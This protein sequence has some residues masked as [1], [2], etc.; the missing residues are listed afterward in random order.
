[1]QL[2]E[3]TYSESVKVDR[4]AGIIRDVKVL[5]RVSKNGREY[6][7]KALG[8]AARLYEGIKVRFD[9]P[10]KNDPGRERQF[11]DS[12]GRLENLRLTADGVFADLPYKKTH[13]Y[14][15]IVCESAERFAKDFGLSHNSEGAVVTKDGKVIVESINKARGVDV[16]DNPASTQG[17]FES[18]DAVP[19]DC[20]IKFNGDDK[21]PTIQLNETMDSN[22]SAPAAAADPPA[23]AAHDKQLKAALKKIIEGILMDDSIDTPT[24]AK[25]MAQ[26]LRH[27]DKLDGIATPGSGI[28][29]MT[30]ESENTN[31]ATAPAQ[32]TAT[33][34]QG[35]VTPNQPA[36]E[37][38]QEDQFRVCLESVVAENNQLKAD[39]AAERQQRT[40]IER[41]IKARRLLESKG[42]EA[43]PYTEEGRRNVDT[44]LKIES[45]SIW[46]T[47]I[48]SWPSK[49]EHRR[50]QRTGS[51]METAA[52]GRRYHSPLDVHDGKSLVAAIFE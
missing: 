9:H 40:L 31:M 52:V 8:D 36:T 16:V 21:L 1:M 24:T 17:I 15:D 33:T 46:T 14:A 35:T 25:K 2:A 19:A 34:Q 18:G 12:F 49:N 42:R 28:P 7:D 27:Y 23:A 29:A 30:Q 10:P 20:A 48:D 4:E 47:L 37:N 6:S 41:E 45:E 32:V 5:G 26:A 11:I 51:V 38:I 50:P 22:A 3:T 44:L 43:N 13:P 39:L